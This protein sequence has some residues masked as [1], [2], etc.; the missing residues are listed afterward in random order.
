MASSLRRTR[1]LNINV[2]LSSA[3]RKSGIL[4]NEAASKINKTNNKR[5]PN[6]ARLIKFINSR[7]KPLFFWKVAGGETRQTT[8]QNN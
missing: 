4:K 5:Q 8:K 6:Q 7:V 1:V 2:E 3:R